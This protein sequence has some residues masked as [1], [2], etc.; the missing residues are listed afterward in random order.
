MTHTPTD[1]TDL[2]GQLDRRTASALDGGALLPIHTEQ[3]GVADGGICFTVRWVSSLAHKDAA[4]VAAVTRRDP[5]FNPFLPPDPALTVT[6]LGPKH[7]AVL[8]KYPVIERHLLIVTCA[9]EAQTAPLTPADFA[10]LTQVMSRHGGLGF[11][12]GGADAGASQAHRHLQ[13]LPAPAG[14]DA[15]T[16]A[17]PPTRAGDATRAPL[18][19]A[20]CFIRLDETA[21][22]DET[23]AALALQA[24]F[25]TACA[26][27][28][29][30]AT[31]DPMP[32]YNLLIDRA[33]LLLVPRSREKHNGISVNALGYAGSLF[34]RNPEQIDALRGQ[35]HDS[36]CGASNPL[37]ILA[38]VGCPA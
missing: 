31:A 18:P 25:S 38:G 34:V 36:A 11:Y 24:A 14:L 21:W 16:V 9:F 12:N 20:H 4:R 10:A 28:G 7:L 6:T 2:L 15:F 17:L 23:I 3:A 26:L 8:N 32:P 33:W 35:A 37:T 27:L 1:A 30:P 22:A 13:W 29:L 5:D 19:W